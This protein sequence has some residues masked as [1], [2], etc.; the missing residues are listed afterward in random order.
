MIFILSLA[1]HALAIKTNIYVQQ[2]K[3]GL[4]NGELTRTGASNATGN[5]LV[6]PI[7]L[8]ICRIE[9]SQK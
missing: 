4:D 3:I 5:K 1:L 6:L 9:E 8:T 7:Q 2:L